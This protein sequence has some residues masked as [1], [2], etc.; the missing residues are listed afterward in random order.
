VASNRARRATPRN[1]TT[2]ELD[3]PFF[4]G[5]PAKTFRQNIR[6][7]MDEVAAQG[8]A[9]VK[10]QLAVGAASRAPIRALPAQRVADYVRGRTTSLAGRRWAVTAVVSVNNSGFSPRQGISLMAAA[11]E[12]ERQTGAF[13]RTSSRL[14]KVARRAEAVLLKGIA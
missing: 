5:D 9:D 13:R 6:A 7:F 3:G 11:S 12:V 8:E 14:R 2:I 10:A 1:T 4:V